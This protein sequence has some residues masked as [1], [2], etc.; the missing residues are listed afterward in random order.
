VLAL[1]ALC[2]QMVVTRYARHKV[3][4]SALAQSSSKSVIIL[5]YGRLFFFVSRFS[6]CKSMLIVMQTHLQPP[7]PSQLGPQLD[8]RTRTS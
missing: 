6:R 4:H 8:L 1:I 5:K 7:W 2:V 3:F